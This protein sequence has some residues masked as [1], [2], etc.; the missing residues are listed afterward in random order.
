MRDKKIR[1]DDDRR[2]RSIVTEGVAKD[3]NKKTKKDLA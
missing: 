3:R 1:I 2:D